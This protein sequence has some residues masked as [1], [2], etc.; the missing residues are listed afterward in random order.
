VEISLGTPALL[1]P[2][3]S[4][5]M[6][7]YTNRFLALAALIR[8]LSDEFKK[9]RNTDVLEQIKALR[10]RIRLILYMQSGGIASLALCVAAMLGILFKLEQLAIMLFASSLSLMLISLVLSLLEIRVSTNALTVALRDL[11]TR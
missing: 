4:L 3:I 1:F 8:R 9:D 6:L 5:L 10:Y 11:E 2:A 7:A